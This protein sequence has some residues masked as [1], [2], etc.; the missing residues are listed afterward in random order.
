MWFN[1]AAAQGHEQAREAR[2]A[3]D[4]LARHRMTPDQIANAQR[5]AREWLEGQDR[6]RE[7]R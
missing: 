7:S 3:R 1:L 5:L 2:E 4:F 6:Q